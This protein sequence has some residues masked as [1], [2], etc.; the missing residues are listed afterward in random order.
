MLVDANT[1]RVDHDDIAVVSLGNRFEKSIPDT[2]LSP[3]DEAIVAG[4]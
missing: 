3:A 2:G 1:G 4:G